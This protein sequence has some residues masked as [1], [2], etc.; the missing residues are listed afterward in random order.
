MNRHFYKIIACVCTLY[1]LYALI[2]NFI[3]NPGAETFLSHK[4]DLERELKP[5]I[6]L[7][8]M[9]IHV[10]FACIAMASGLVN[11]A[12]RSYVKHRTL[13]RLN[14]YVYAASVLAVVLTSGYMAP[15][16]TGGKI[17]SMG[18][19]L[20]NILWLIFTAAALIHIFKKRI[21]QHRRWMIRSYAFCFTNML[22][23]LFTFGLNQVAGVEYSTS[24]T[25][26]LYGSIVLL[27]AAPEALF[28]IEKRIG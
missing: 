17:S 5:R 16:A 20:L 9:Y 13:H 19:N 4:A 18:F 8:V 1:I 3:I 14:G 22:I 26:G 12:S 24:Y 11:F 15:F 28:R 27:L 7:T 2:N 21:P 23:H 25:I 10:G 6:W